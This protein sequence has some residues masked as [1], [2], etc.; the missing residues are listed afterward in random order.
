MAI[1]VIVSHHAGPLPIEVAFQAP[2]DLPMYLEVNGSVWSGNTN[3]MTGI[4]VML[5][6]VLLG[7]AQIYS[8]ASST[9]RTVVPAYFPIQ[10]N[11]GNHTLSLHALNTETV[12]D[13]NDSYTA[14]IHY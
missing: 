7:S 6:G 14:V 13:V 11:E 10:L 4:S 3:V 9:H 1:Q 8:N 5:D 2:S 12:S